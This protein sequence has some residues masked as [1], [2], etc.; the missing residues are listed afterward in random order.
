MVGYWGRPLSTDFSKEAADDHE[1][2]G[3]HATARPNADADYV[4]RPEHL[5]TTVPFAEARA[6]QKRLD[7]WTKNYRIADWELPL[8]DCAL[9]GRSAPP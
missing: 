2:Q 6:W 5:L 4:P 8:E 7:A 1:G 9:S 3:C